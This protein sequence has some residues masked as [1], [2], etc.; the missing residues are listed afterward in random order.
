MNNK[1]TPEYLQDFLQYVR[2]NS[3]Y[4]GTLWKAA[5]QG[6]SSIENLPLTDLD[7]YWTAAKQNKLLTRGL[8]DGSVFRTGGTTSEPNVVYVARDEINQSLPYSG[9]A[10]A[11]SGIVPGDRIANL[12]HV[13]GLY[14]GFAKMTMTL[15]HVH[16]PHVH[17]P[18]TG[19]EAIPDIANFMQLFKATVIFSNVFTVCRI[20]DHLVEKG[21]TVDSVH[22]ILFAGES[23][24]K[25]LRTSWRR[26]FPNMRAKPLMYGAA[27]GGL[28]GVPLRLGAED[29]DIKPTYQVSHP[30]IVLEILD[31]DGNVI[32]EPGRKGRVVL[33][34]VKRR[35]HPAVRY[36][37]GD[38]AHW[39]DY[40]QATFE[41]LG[42]ETVALKVGSL[43][44]SI[45]KLR[46]LVAATLGEG[47]Q[48]SFQTILRRSTGKNEVTFRFAATPK[49]AEAATR[50]LEKNLIAE[51]PKWGEYL[52]VGY[53][54]PLKTEWVKVKDLV[55]AE[56]SGKLKEIIEERFVEKGNGAE[57]NG[58]EKNGAVSN[59]A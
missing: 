39:V 28:I 14:A 2:D 57:K 32:R 20:V 3:H 40:N 24:Y 13:G 46:S 26:A 25:D 42:R 16:V 6:V 56:K 5:P 12:F 54:Q 1:L 33:T 58:T 30:T 23:F 37:M 43:F 15:Q 36:P 41:L 7:G 21:E 18:I 31:D 19:N 8:F 47:F 49:D 29:E 11:N 35:L 9:A 45:P 4:Y 34:D 48:D 27:D 44:L 38:M 53:I 59:G 22:L 55:Y 50:A 52:D 17:L 10:F 51:F